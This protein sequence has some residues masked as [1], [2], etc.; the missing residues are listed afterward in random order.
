[1]KITIT[2]CKKKAKIIIG[3]AMQYKVNG[4]QCERAYSTEVVMED[5]SQAMTLT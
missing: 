4:V 3:L 2:D 5:F 1:M